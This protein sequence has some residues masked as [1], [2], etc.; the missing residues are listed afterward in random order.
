MYK[1]L[2]PYRDEWLQPTDNF[3]GWHKATT[4]LQSLAV[5]SRSRSVVDIG[6]G[7]NPMLS[8]E[9]VRSQSIEYGLIDI[10]QAELD[11]APSHY[12]SRVCV[13][14]TARSSDFIAALGDRK[15]DMAF[16]HMFLEHVKDAR[17]VHRNIA[18]LLPS[19]GLAVH[20]YPSPNN[21]PLALNRVLPET[22][23][24][25][26]LRLAHP[27]RDIE[28]KQGK[29]PAYYRMCG[30][31]SRRLHKVFEEIGYEV[32]VQCGFVGHN[33]YERISIM[34]SIARAMVKPLVQ[35]GIGLTS[36]QLLVLQKT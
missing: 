34:D 32:L 24:A 16:S 7:A 1:E 8:A 20:M 14:V 31:R 35:L 4:L 29:F 27:G 6:G 11:K 17:Q 25:Q 2:E 33:Y 5:S 21:I 10:S 9:F 23:S 26:L 12:T 19:G 3:P 36:F 30:N 28:G 22:V 13:D 15:F 18:N